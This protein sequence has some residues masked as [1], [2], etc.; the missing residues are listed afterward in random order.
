MRSMPR[1]L[2]H[3]SDAGSMALTGGEP[4]CTRDPQLVAVP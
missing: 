4:L 2:T 3:P 1:I